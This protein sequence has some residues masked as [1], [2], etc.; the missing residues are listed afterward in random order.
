MVVLRWQRF[1]V[2]HAVTCATMPQRMTFRNDGQLTIRHRLRIAIS[3]ARCERTQRRIERRAHSVPEPRDLNISQTYFVE[4][5]DGPQCSCGFSL[6]QGCGF[7]NNGD[8]VST[9]NEAHVCLR[10]STYG[11]NRICECLFNG[12]MLMDACFVEAMELQGQDETRKISG[13]GSVTLRDPAK[14]GLRYLGTTI[15]V[16]RAHMKVVHRPR[17]S[18]IITRKI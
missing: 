7:E 9:C 11:R 8:A 15:N 6:A 4:T 18:T 10:G 14:V 2:R 17:P 1:E 13:V 3:A 16:K 5:R 12:H